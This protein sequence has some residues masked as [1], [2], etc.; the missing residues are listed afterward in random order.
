MIQFNLFSKKN[1]QQR[2]ERKIQKRRCKPWF[3]INGDKTL[4][5]NYDLSQSSIV[6]DLGGYKGNFAQ[7][8]YKRYLCKIFIFEPVKS[9]YKIIDNKFK[10]I[11]KVT[12]YPFGLANNDK[13]LFI[14]NSEDASSVF[15]DS[16]GSEKIKLK[17]ILTFINDNKITHVDLIKINIEGGEYEVLESLLSSGMIPIF[18]N[19][20]IQFHDF[21]IDNANERMENIQAQLAKTHKITYQ[22]K[23]VWENWEIK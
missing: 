12:A 23:F 9:F 11:P 14:S 21:I 7:E 6:F 1:N 2:K 3:K 22:Y 18:K 5:L 17:S 8:I 10:N 15:I 20:Q 4:R 19:L 13:E 16:D